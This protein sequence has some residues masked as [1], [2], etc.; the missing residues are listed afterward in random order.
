[1]Q[2]AGMSPMHSRPEAPT[3]ETGI[4]GESRAMRAIQAIISRVARSDA[5]VL[6]EGE[7]GTG[8]EL[9]AR[10]IHRQSPRR[11]RAFATENCAALTESLIESEL[12]GHVKGA[13]TG[14]TRDRL[15]IFQ[16]ADGGTLFL[17]EIG[18]MSPSMQGKFLRVLQEGEVRPVGGRHVLRV[19]VRIV[20]ATNRNL[21]ELMQSGRFRQDLYYRLNVVRISIPALRERRDDIPNLVRHFM[22]KISQEQSLPE[23]RI[24]PDVMTLLMSYCWPGNVRELE[25][26]IERAILMQRD[27]AIHID[28]LPTEILDYCLSERRSEYGQ[29]LKNEEQIMI[30]AALR[31]FSGD[32]SKTARS[33]GW[34]RPKLYRRL[35]ELG[36]P[37]HFG[38]IAGADGVVTPADGSAG[39]S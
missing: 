22:R 35:R 1:M 37:L 32:K 5:G 14:A 7:S 13:F 8:K 23:P 3:S 36:I 29:L 18:E 10:A 27:S 2:A 9:I 31:K 19:D 28:G 15:G 20:A 30:E 33:I 25:N 24:S 39:S 16:L 38:R 12:F 34:N 17:D 6:I 21:A 26:A 4:I 11:E